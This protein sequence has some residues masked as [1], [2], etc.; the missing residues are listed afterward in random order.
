M[1]GHPVSSRR[2]CP[3]KQ[4]VRR[5]TAGVRAKVWASL[6]RGHAA[7]RERGGLYKCLP[8]RRREAVGDATALKAVKGLK[9][10]RIGLRESK[11]ILSHFSLPP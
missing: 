1:T 11:I 8:P 6:F 4:A 10:F 3:G 7:P 9:F 2:G 5:G